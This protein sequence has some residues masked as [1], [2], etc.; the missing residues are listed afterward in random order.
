[1]SEL[2]TPESELAPSLKMAVL[3]VK[4]ALLAV[5]FFLYTRSTA[6]PGS[7]NSV[8][9]FARSA[10]IPPPPP[11]QDPWYTAPDGYESTAP[12]TVLRVRNNPSTSA[13][14]P[15]SSAAYNILYR[16][17]DA[18]YKPSWAVTTLLIPEILSNKSEARA[19]TI[20]PGSLINYELA[21]Q[22]QLS[23]PICTNP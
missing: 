22:F 10:N 11:S 15:N 13:L 9:N 3:S 1:V 4:L 5:S 20:A 19:G 2:D 7:K 23:S 8:P 21:C 16:T 17:T 6:L 12:G 18:N 14:V